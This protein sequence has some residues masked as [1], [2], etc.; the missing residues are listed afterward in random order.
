VTLPLS[1]ADTAF[2]EEV[3]A[4][5]ARTLTPELQ[6][7]GRRCAGIYNDRPEAEAWLKILDGQGWAVPSWPRAWGGADWTPSQ[8]YVF[9]RELALAEAPQITPNAL[10]MV[11][12]VIIA[13]GSEDQKAQLLPR[14][15]TG[16]DWWAQG[17]SEPE[18]GSDLAA[19]QCRAVRDGGD[20]VV[21]GSKIWTSHAQWSNKI[22]CLVRTSDEGRPQAGISFLL[23]DLG[24]PGVSVRPIRSLSGDHEVNAVFFDDVRVP[25]SGLLGQE[26]EG[27]KIAKFLL[28]HE[29]GA[30]WSPQC[31]ARFGRLR[32]RIGAQAWPLPHGLR[33]EAAAFE[34]ALEALEVHELRSAVKAGRGV[35]DNATASLLKIQGSELRQRLGELELA[36]ANLQADPAGGIPAAR[37]DTPFGSGVMARYLNDRAASIY[38]GTNEVQ[39]NILAQA[40]L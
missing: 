2:R 12:P 5:L 3:R 17:Y 31:R 22:F 32:A 19:L 21:S 10:R 7:A 28:Q 9:E 23:F 37:R 29:R 16:D 18:A 20:Y 1:P 39:R 13:F 34:C 25:A 8:H 30:A 15:R 6:E 26:N 4:F 33:A 35:F 24:L 38:A 27:W 11:G 40:I 36:I 14:I